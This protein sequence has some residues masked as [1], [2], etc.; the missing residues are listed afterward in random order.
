[1]IH[2]IISVRVAVFAEGCLRASGWVTEINRSQVTKDKIRTDDSQESVL[3][4]PVKKKY[5][6]SQK[7]KIFERMKLLRGVFISRN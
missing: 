4:K 1:M 5:H 3:R 6:L 7:R 2:N